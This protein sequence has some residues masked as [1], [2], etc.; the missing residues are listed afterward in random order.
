MKFVDF[1]TA[2]N[3]LLLEKNDFVTIQ[4]E[5]SFVAKR[6]NE[7]IRIDSDTITTPRVIPREEFV[8]VYKAS[9]DY[10]EAERFHPGNYSKITQNASY[11]ITLF[12]HI[13]NQK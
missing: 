7:A 9:L 5:K 4:Q 3:E 10:L 2:L 11:I 12:D 1:W 8:K 6:A 13:M